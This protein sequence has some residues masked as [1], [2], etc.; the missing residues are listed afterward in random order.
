MSDAPLLS[1]EK[2]ER[3]FGGGRSL[4]GQPKPAVHAVQDVTIEVRKGETLALVGESGCGKST[5][6]RAILRLTEPVSGSVTLEGQDVSTLS[7]KALMRLRQSMQMIFQDPFSSLNPRMRIGEAIAEPLLI[8]GLVAPAE[9]HAK[10]AG[11]L[12]HVGLSPDMATR[13]PHEFSGGQRQRVAIARALVTRPRL[14][15]LDEPVSALDVSVRGDVLG[16]LSRLQEAH[17]LTYLII[18]HDLDM[19]AAMADRVLV[20]EKGKI[21]EEGAPQRLFAEPQHSLTKALMAARLPEI[22]A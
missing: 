9:A 7:R 21:V 15:V 14:V 11:L 22:A 6:G 2:A 10:V 4:F 18:S 17:G 3:V 8:H 16:L 19:V 12:E 20:M 1:I 13:W 5:T